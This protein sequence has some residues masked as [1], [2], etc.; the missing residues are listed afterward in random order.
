MT[1]DRG[2]RYRLGIDIGGSNIKGGVVD[3]TRGELVGERHVVSTP[4]PCTPEST[5]QTVADIADHFGWSGPVGVTLP[6]VVTGGIVRTAANIHEA[7]IGTDARDLFSRALQGVDV[8]VV[9]DADAAGLAEYR[10]GAATDGVV[11]VVTFGTGIGSALL[12]DGLLVPN[13]ELGHMHVAGIE[14]EKLAAASVKHRRQL[15]FGDW[16]D[17]AS[18]VLGHIENLFW[19]DL[20]VVGGEISRDG[21]EWIPLLSVRTPV[22]AAG[23]L[24]SAGVIGAA[25]AA[26]SSDL[27]AV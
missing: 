17:R 26:R 4:Q 25:L 12:H 7:W 9:N 13:T 11:I 14:A 18:T 24:N 21:S 20:F 2:A 1:V 3:V 23:L 8:T 5:A 10:Y 27:V 22:V 15:S 19:P 16:A 6:A